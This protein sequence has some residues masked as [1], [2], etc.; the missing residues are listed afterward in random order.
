MNPYKLRAW[1]CDPD[2]D[3]DGHYTTAILYDNAEDEW[4]IDGDGAWT[5]DELEQEGIFIERYIRRTDSNNV[6]I[7]EE[8]IVRVREWTPGW[9][10]SD[11][12]HKYNNYLVMRS[13]HQ[14]PID[15]GGN[16]IGYPTYDDYDPPTVIGNSRERPNL[17][18]ES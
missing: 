18:E 6:A 11:T 4:W 13:Y 9:S 17:L 14:I 3:V 5:T 10:H 15:E 8:D 16:V 2:N 1:V 12:P 7:Y